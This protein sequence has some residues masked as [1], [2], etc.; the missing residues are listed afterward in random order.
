MFEKEIDELEELKLVC[1][2]DDRER[3]S[4]LACCERTAVIEAYKDAQKQVEDVKQRL[5]E[6]KF[7][8]DE[9]TSRIVDD[10]DDLIVVD[11]KD[12][13]EVLK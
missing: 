12:L 3:E 9:W 13:N 2:E 1:C 8:V 6:K 10:D 7:K 4:C 11:I 5:F